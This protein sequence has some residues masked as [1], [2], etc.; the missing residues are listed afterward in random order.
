M[1]KLR[2]GRHTASLTLHPN[3]FHKIISYY[4]AAANQPIRVREDQGT[5]GYMIEYGGSHRAKTLPDFRVEIPI[6]RLD[7]VSEVGE[8]D[9]FVTKAN[10]GLRIRPYS[11]RALTRA[12]QQAKREKVHPS[13]L[14]PSKPKPIAQPA[15]VGAP[16]GRRVRARAFASA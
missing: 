10:E 15:V 16:S 14:I 2:V 3:E 1:A 4:P 7:L 13:K 9:V 11:A 5:Q 12:R 6:S 8:I